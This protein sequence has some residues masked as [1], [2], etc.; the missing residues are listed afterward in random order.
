MGRKGIT[1]SVIFTLLTQPARFELIDWSIVVVYLVLVVLIGWIVSVR[2]GSGD[3]MLLAGRSMPMWAVAISVLATSQSA[4]TF[5][6]GPEE[7][8][9]R[10][11]T[12]LSAN[13]GALIAVVIVAVL[14]IPAYYRHN[15]T[16]V[17][18]LIGHRFGG[19]AQR[20]ASAMFMIGRVFASGA[21]L[22]IAAI[23]F[24]LIAFNDVAPAHLMAAIGIIT[25]GAAAYTM[26]GGIRAV[27]WTDV[28]Q[29]AIYIGSIIIALALLW[30]RLDLPADQIMQTLSES[31]K[32]TFIDAEMNSWDDLSKPYSI[33]AILLG[34]TL[35]NMAA[36]GA[37]QDLTQRMLTCRSARSGAW[38]VIVANLIGWP[39]ILLF[40]LMGLLLFVHYEGATPHG[41]S[42]QVFLRF[43]L[44][45]TTPALRGLMMAGLFAAA[46]SSL[47]SAL[48]AMA[49]ATVADFW[50][51][52]VIRKRPAMTPGS[53]RERTVT[54]FA[55]C[56][57][58]V[59]LAG[60]A[61][62]CVS[63]QQASGQTLIAFAL[64]V[65]VFAYSGLLA[66]F[67]TAI[68]TKR[69]NAWS[70]AASLATGFLVTLLLQDFLW[71]KWSPLLGLEFTLAFSWKML[72]A[73]VLSL[74]VCCAGNRY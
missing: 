50:R 35:F 7:A 1:R 30:A 17:Y 22:F 10:N 68:L 31:G 29:A 73:T 20:L 28:V 37:D 45:E 14:F 64:G 47:D 19:G 55:I 56:F 60:F 41:D 8:F 25:V 66:V 24:S 13:I 34:L 16:S 48:N 18:E 57:W 12:Y 53:V 61:C 52:W 62:L 23:P 32:M 65:M 21:R 58:A 67:L 44:D 27:I 6:G 54:R 43:I 63:W 42:R 46:M 2:R 15:V 4:A 59:L 5:I 74:L 49:S 39:V 38:S 33:V 36:F 72:I 51:P 70:A 26:M 3:D 69:G 40:M 71:N 11:L 9:S